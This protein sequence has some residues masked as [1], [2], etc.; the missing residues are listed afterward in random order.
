MQLQHRD[1]RE[2]RGLDAR[3]Q[4]VLE[5]LLA[6]RVV[7]GVAA[8]LKEVRED[9]VVRAVARHV[10]V[11]DE[12]QGALKLVLVH[13]R[14]DQDGV[15]DYVGVRAIAAPHLVIEFQGL[16]QAVGADQ[17][18]DE[19][20]AHHS[21]HGP[22]AAHKQVHNLVGSAHV[23]VHDAGV[24]QRAEC[25][26]VGLQAGAEHLME[27]L[28]AVGRLAGLREALDDRVVG[29]H[30]DNFIGQPSLYFVRLAEKVK[31]A[32]GLLGVDTGEQQQVEHKCRD[33]ITQ[34]PEDGFCSSDVLQGHVS[35]EEKHVVLGI[36]V[37]LPVPLEHC[38]CTLGGAYLEPSVDEA[39]ENHFVGW[40]L[41]AENRVRR[42][43]RAEVL[44]AGKHLQRGLPER[45]RGRGARSLHRPQH[46]LHDVDLAHADGRLDEGGVE[47]GAEVPVPA[48]ALQHAVHIQRA[49]ELALVQVPEHLQLG[50]SHERRRGPGRGRGCRLLLLLA[51][52]G[53]AS[54][55][56]RR[57]APGARA[58]LAP[59]AEGDEEDG[60][61]QQ[62]LREGPERGLLD[63]RRQLPER[64]AV[65]RHGD[66][67]DRYLLAWWLNVRGSRP[68][69][70]PGGSGY[71][72]PI[73]KGRTSHKRG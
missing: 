11:L 65:E 33:L 8:A 34:L 32:L 21:V 63:E 14:L 30:V 5:E 55:A 41:G 13:E 20:R 58:Q 36:N 29:D 51:E 6:E 57:L 66:A 71:G 46:P 44:P 50:S 70:G 4:Q 10:H 35:P 56:R 16:R 26:V 48:I 7:A 28:E 3:G 22:V 42:E 19:E 27:A 59:G 61:H 24:K 68:S 37:G 67:L 52:F 45:Q 72:R 38:R 9:D 73:E 69:L 25:D 23:V 2:L 40:D 15:G 54:G 60:Q 49:R 39:R 43:A 17:A 12:P 1:E 64:G 47:L 31:A 62:L 18:L 53:R